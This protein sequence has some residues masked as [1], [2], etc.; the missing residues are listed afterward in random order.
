M[1]QRPSPSDDWIALATEKY[2]I[3]VYRLAYA[4][5]RS[6]QDAE[7]VTAKGLSLCFF[8]IVRIR[9]VCVRLQLC[10]SRR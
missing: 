9:S 4:R 5:T 8:G 1:I 3:T 10:R 7:D 2:L 6:R